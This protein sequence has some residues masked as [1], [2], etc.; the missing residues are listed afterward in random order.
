MICYEYYADH[1]QLYPVNHDPELLSLL[2]HL[3][4]SD[5]SSIHKILKIYETKNKYICGIMSVIISILNQ[6]CNILFK[7]S[8]K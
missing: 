6:Q 4:H 5:L 2:L 7:N 8:Q 3:K 1:I